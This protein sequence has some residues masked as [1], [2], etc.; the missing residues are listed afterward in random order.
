MKI[1]IQFSKEEA[2]QRKKVTNCLP[3]CLSLYLSVSLI[4]AH[5]GLSQPSIRPP[6]GIEKWWPKGGISLSIDI[7][8]LPTGRE[9][10]HL[11]GSTNTLKSE[12]S[13]D[14]SQIEFVA[15]GP[16]T[17]LAEGVCRGRRGY[18]PLLL[19]C[20]ENGHPRPVVANGDEKVF[21]FE[22]FS[23]RKNVFPRHLWQFKRDRD[24][25][26]ENE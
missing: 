13:G 12:W 15:I 10:Q 2:L 17:L 7:C 21:G 5:R 11:T 19:S 14:R 25:G 26:G 1:N 16:P 23:F 6:K 18:D 22:S 3:V 8:T 9:C 20:Q 4:V 24:R